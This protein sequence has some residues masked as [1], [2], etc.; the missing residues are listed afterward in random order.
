MTSESGNIYLWQV[1]NTELC[2]IVKLCVFSN[3]E[4]LHVTHV[5]CTPCDKRTSVGVLTVTD[6]VMPI[7]KLK[8]KK[9]HWTC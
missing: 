3:L 2:T 8:C 1:D 6:S 7:S 9:K 5:H 4:T